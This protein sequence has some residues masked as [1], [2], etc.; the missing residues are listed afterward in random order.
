M[1]GILSI[2]VCCCSWMAA[3]KPQPVSSECVLAFKLEQQTVT[4]LFSQCSLFLSS[5]CLAGVS[6]LST[7]WHNAAIHNTASICLLK[8]SVIQLK[9]NYLLLLS[10]GL[11]LCAGS[12]PTYLRVHMLWLW[13]C[14]AALPKPTWQ[15]PSMLGVP[16]QEDLLT[17]PMISISRENLW[18]LGPC[19]VV[20]TFS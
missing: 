3:H 5:K 11:G 4:T 18:T 12:A 1:L 14:Q 16:P 10:V 20:G 6:S 2:N 8:N 13:L 7:L 9:D 17:V 19:T 15:T